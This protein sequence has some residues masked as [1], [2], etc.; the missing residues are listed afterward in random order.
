MAARP[1]GGTAA[2]RRRSLAVIVSKCKAAVGRRRSRGW[3][4]FSGNCGHCFPPSSA[5]ARFDWYTVPLFEFFHQNLF[6]QVRLLL[7]LEDEKATSS[8]DDCLPAGSGDRVD[9]AQRRATVDAA[10]G[11]Q[12]WAA[13]SLPAEPPRRLRR[14]VCARAL[15]PPDPSPR[16]RAFAGSTLSVSPLLLV[17]SSLLLLSGR[18]RRSLPPQA[19]VAA[20]SLREPAPRGSP[21]SAPRGRRHGRSLSPLAAAAASTRREKDGIRYG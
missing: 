6:D 2:N 21:P 20:P 1:T 18:C 7:P 16:R 10:G 8:D 4:G 11:G 9:W 12:I 3:S 17:K 15:A 19:S 14:P 5:A 13:P